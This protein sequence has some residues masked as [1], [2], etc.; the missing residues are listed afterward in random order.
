MTVSVLIPVYN[1]AEALKKSL[2]SLAK[3]TVLP[4]E[5]IIVD[6]GSDV[7]ICID[8]GLLAQLSIS[9]IR[10]KNAGAPAARNTGFEASSSDT[11]IFWDADVVA[12]PQLLEK[13]KQVLE[14]RKDIDFVYA[15]YRFPIFSVRSWVYTKHIRT[16]AFDERILQKNNYIHSTSL[17]RRHAVVSWDTALRRFQDWDF[18]LTVSERGSRGYWIDETLF[19]VSEQGSMST[20]L[21]ACAYRAPWKFLPFV[22]SRVAAYEKAKRGVEVKHGLFPERE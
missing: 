13:M 17:I 22:R 9:L 12:E 6:D 10:Q 15:N 14:E 11:V 5:V 16:R 8:E 20:W 2:A 4:D 19:T 1:Q 18:W 3:Q 21:P 7:P